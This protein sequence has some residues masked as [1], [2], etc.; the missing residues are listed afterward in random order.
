MKTIETK[1]LILRDF[2]QED[3][4]D[5][6]AYAQSD[7][8]GPMA[9]WKPHDSIE[10]SQKI[11][12]MF[13]EGKEVWA[14]ELKENHKLI[15]SIGL[16]KDAKR[17]NPK[18]AMLGYVLSEEAWGKG[19][20]IEAS[21]AILNFGFNED[22]LTLISVYHFPFNKQSESVI[23]NLGFKYEGYMRETTERYDGV[24]LDSVCYSMTKEEFNAL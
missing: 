9:G 6:F 15:G 10:E 8:V 14:I 12:N 24:V 1:R 21:R 5:L 11:L 13:I 19:F 4:N 22:D 20:M 7:K 2:S 3:L 17:N 23:K 18:S 16:H